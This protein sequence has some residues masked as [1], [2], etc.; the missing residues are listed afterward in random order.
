MLFILSQ[1]EYTLADKTQFYNCFDSKTDVNIFADNWQIIVTLNSVKNS[2]C[3]FPHGVLITLQ[4]DSLGSYKPQIY[5]ADFNY[6]STKKIF[7][8]CTDISCTNAKQ[9]KSAIIIIEQKTDYTEIPVGSVRVSRGVANNCFNDNDSYVELYQGYIIVIL[10]PVIT[11]TQ[12]NQITYVHPNGSLMMNTPSAAKLYMTYDDDSKSVHTKLTIT[13]LSS[14]YVPSFGFNINTTVGMRLKLASPE[15]SDKFLQKLVDGVPTPNLKFFHL[16]L[17]FTTDTLAPIPLIKTASLLMN[18]YSL[19]GLPSAYYF[20]SIQVISGGFIISQ[21]MGSLGPSVNQQLV[22]SNID[23]YYM[24]FIFTMYDVPRTNEFTI[25][26]MELRTDTILQTNTQQVTCSRFPKQE[27][28]K[29]MDRLGKFKITDLTG[30]VVYYY[31]S[32]GNYITNSTATIFLITDSCFEDG[33]LSYDPVNLVLNVT[34]LWHQDALGCK[35]VDNDALTVNI[36]D[37]SNNLVFTKQ[38]DFLQGNQSYQI[39][40]ENFSTYPELKIQYMRYGEL[41]DALALSSYTIIPNAGLILIQ[42]KL[43]VY[44]LAIHLSFVI[45]YVLTKFIIIPKIQIARKK[46]PTFK[47]IV[48]V[49]EAL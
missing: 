9:S 26:L 36:Y 21:Q 12:S 42:I 41:V 16:H 39:T 17:Y 33:Y 15:I 46:R 45:L 48:D 14:L 11:C 5:I 13:L 20:S 34:V 35:L 6:N 44:I 32:N 1:C 38:T 47:K 29:Y 49:D 23:S 2:Q 43:V 22:N 18:F 8:N 10:V 40:G 25:R 4:M 24:D 37:G 19:A 27:C 28:R 31:Y 3:V 7:M 30:Y